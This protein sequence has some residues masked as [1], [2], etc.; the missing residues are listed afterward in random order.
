MSET[1]D[2]IQE[3]VKI[4]GYADDWMIFTSHKDVRTCETRMQKAMQQI[5]KWTNDT[6]FQIS[7][8]K[9][10]S[11][12]F[13]RKNYEIINRP[14]INIWIKEERIEQVRQHRILGLIFDSRM[15]SNEHILYA[16]AKAEK[17][18]PNQM[19]KS[20]QM[21]SRSRKFHQNAPNDNLQHT[22][23]RWGSIWLSITGNL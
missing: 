13:S 2:G 19:P 17:N 8:E 16:M 12:L 7:I 3:P 9:T 6:G 20:H 22:Q 1:Y 18:E 5:I 11:N 14:K 23:I 21:G 10:K 15:T 4:I